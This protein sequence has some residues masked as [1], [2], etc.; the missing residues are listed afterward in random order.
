[1]QSQKTTWGSPQKSPHNNMCRTTESPGAF[2]ANACILASLE[3]NPVQGLGLQVRV[4]R[5]QAAGLFIAGQIR[6][7][8]PSRYFAE[9]SGATCIP[10]GCFGNWRNPELGSSTST[11]L[12][13]LLNVAL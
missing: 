10:P 4:Q 11:L 6:P 7:K 13:W 12:S 3:Q 1:M 2:A 5:L 9:G 8:V